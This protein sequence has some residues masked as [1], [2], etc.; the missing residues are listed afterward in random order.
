MIRVLTGI[1]NNLH[2][3]SLNNF[4]EVARRVFGW[5]QREARARG[6][7]DAVDL[8][9]E[10]LPADRID[11]HSHALARTHVLQLR[12]LEVRRHPDFVER[13]DRHQRLA[14]LNDLSLFDGL[15]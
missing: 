2:W 14:W 10:F 12:L 1:E 7:G 9:R 13:N 11:L 8:A 15:A 6:G 3:H 5:Q 4:D